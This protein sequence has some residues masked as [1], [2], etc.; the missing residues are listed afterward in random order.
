MQPR[1]HNFGAGPAALPLSVLEEAQRDLLSLPGVGM[2]VL[3]ISHRSKHF[4]AIQQETI[5]NLRQLLGLAPEQQVLF[6]PGGASL[7]F[8]L[9]PMN[10]CPAGKK[11]DYIVT[12]TWSDK[13]AKDA[14]AQGKGRR[15]WSG[16][17]GNYTRLPLAEELTLDPE[18]AYLHY[19]SNETI[20]GVQFHH[21]PEAG[22]TPLVCDMSSDFLSRPIEASRFSLI[23]AGAQK[24]AGPAGVTVVIVHDAMLERS[25][26]SLPPMLSYAL[27]AKE[28]SIYNTPPVFP[29]Y[30][31]MLVT[32]WLLANGGLSGIAQENEAKAQRLYSLIDASTGFYRPHAQADCRSRMNVAWRL[33]SE[34]LEKT[35]LDQAKARG[36][37]GLKGHRSVGGIRASIY[38]AVPKQSVEAL[39]AFMEEFRAAEAAA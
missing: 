38:N 14:E 22:P 11:A 33:P 13:A 20:H 1:I 36:F 10:L 35:F 31:V 8:T 23:Y 3:E 28:N 7:Q 12:G 18:A 16:K 2:S 9:V 25:P 39:A 26:A 17:A 19:T 34:E 15:L 29:I 5:T 6:L 24:N 30:V 37:D 4:D 27:Q 32:R 21:V